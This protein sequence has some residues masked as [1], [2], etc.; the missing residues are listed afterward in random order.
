M[1]D[2]TVEIVLFF[3]GSS[4]LCGLDAMKHKQWRAY[5]LWGLA[6][7]FALSGASW[8]FTKQLSPAVTAFVTAIAVN[9][10]AWFILFVLGVV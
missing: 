4:L 10:I 8:Q 9:P 3:F 7:A 2:H 1:A 6:G 5:A